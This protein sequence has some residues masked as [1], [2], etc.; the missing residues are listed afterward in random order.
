MLT[1]AEY[2]HAE[3]KRKENEDKALEMA[4]RRLL[5][6]GVYYP[7]P[8]NGKSDTEN[9]D[10]IMTYTALHSSYYARALQAL[11]RETPKPNITKTESYKPYKDD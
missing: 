8:N 2:V 1:A 5:R 6:E 11:D 4:E 10:A 3:R 9:Y 7:I